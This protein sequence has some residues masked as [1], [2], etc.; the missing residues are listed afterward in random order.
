M[1]NKI[2]IKLVQN[3]RLQWQRHALERMLERGISR[4][5]VKQ[6]LTEGE[7]IEH[8]P[9]D[10][11]FPSVLVLGFLNEKPLH[12]VIGVDKEA[13]WCYVVTVYRPDSDHFQQDFKTRK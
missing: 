2:I 1:S 12:V 4:N 8:Y 6:V 9:D 11:P 13:N 3:G 10:R 5:E 7:I